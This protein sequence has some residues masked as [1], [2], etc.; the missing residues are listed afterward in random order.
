M[1]LAFEVTAEDVDNVLKQ[2]GVTLDEDA[3]DLLLCDNEER[4]EQAA[5]A[6]NNMD[7]QTSSALDEI[8]NILIEDEVLPV[9]AAKKFSAP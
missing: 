7:D 9:D 6:Y 4:L 8:E 3:K 2:H 1:S 5:L